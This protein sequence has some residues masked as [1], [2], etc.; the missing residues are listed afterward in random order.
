[1]RP[2]KTQIRLHPRSLTSNYA[3]HMSFVQITILLLASVDEMSGLSQPWSQISED[4]FSRDV[5]HFLSDLAASLHVLF[6]AQKCISTVPNTT[7]CSQQS[8]INGT[9]CYGHYQYSSM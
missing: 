6:T 2:T 1:M 4:R 7:W 3:L 5:G 9:V 8:H